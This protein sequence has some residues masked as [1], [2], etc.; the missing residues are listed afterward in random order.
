MRPSLEAGKAVFIEWPV[1]EN[2]AASRALL[3]PGTD[4]KFKGALERSVVGLQGPVTPI[5]LKL[6]EILNSGRIGKVLGSEARI[7]A[8][9]LDRDRLPEGLAYFVERKVGGSTL[10]IT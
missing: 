3:E 5:L 7:F 1:A 6:K 8:N 4:E 10:T 2:A 9:M